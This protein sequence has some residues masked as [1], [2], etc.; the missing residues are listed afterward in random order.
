[1]L[2]QKRAAVAEDVEEYRVLVQP[3]VRDHLQQPL[4]DVRHL[5]PA[6]EQALHRR[7]VAQRDAA[8]RTRGLINRGVGRHRSPFASEFVGLTRAYPTL[9]FIS[10]KTE[11]H[12]I[13]TNIPDPA[14]RIIHRTLS[15]IVYYRSSKVGSRKVL[16]TVTSR[17]HLRSSCKVALA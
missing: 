11:H 8:A 10:T 7:R 2:I 3:L 9:S 14:R 13:S 6:P 16:R 5:V 12:C 17:D 1:M 15:R 4:A